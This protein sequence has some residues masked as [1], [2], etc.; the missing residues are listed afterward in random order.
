MREFAERY[1]AAWNS[2]VAERVAA[3]F[4]GDGW[5]RVNGGEAARGRAAIAGVA[6]GFLDAFPD[7][8]LQCDGVAE[9]GH[10]VTYLWTFTGTYVGT[11]RKVRISGRELWTI[12]AD[13]LIA[14]SEGSFDAEDYARQCGI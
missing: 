6:K 12:A 7:M 2:G 9:D 4:S 10:A 8:L 1:T 3:H 13:G 14:E 11:G 5:L